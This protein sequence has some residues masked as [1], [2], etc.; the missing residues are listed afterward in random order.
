MTIPPQ[1]D[2]THKVN[3]LLVYIKMQ[4]QCK[5]LLDFRTASEGCS[6]ELEWRAN[7][8]LPFTFTATLMH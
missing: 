8:G 7:Y 3:K 6:F 1:V 4:I 5:E 2:I